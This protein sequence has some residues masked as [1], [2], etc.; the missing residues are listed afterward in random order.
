MTRGIMYSFY[1]CVCH[2]SQ[3][4]LHDISS[5]GSAHETNSK[6]NGWCTT[7]LIPHACLSMLIRPGLLTSIDRISPGKPPIKST[8]KKTCHLSPCWK[9]EMGRCSVY[10]YILV[11]PIIIDTW[12]YIQYFFFV[13]FKNSIQVHQFHLY[14]PMAEAA[15]SG[16]SLNHFGLYIIWT[17]SS[18]ILAKVT[19][20]IVKPPTLC[21]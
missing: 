9:L 8:Q 14:F 7:K 15:A 16:F 10:E 3:K 20:F 13:S 18:I 17:S 11:A 1:I 19:S 5:V 21:V 12:C 4:H 6:F 2:L